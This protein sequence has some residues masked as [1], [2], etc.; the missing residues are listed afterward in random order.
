MPQAYFPPLDRCLAGEEHLISWKTAYRV[1]S[2]SDNALEERTL[3]AFLTDSDSL[4][5][6]VNPLDP[7]PHRS[8]KTKG[9]FE[10]KTAPINVSQ[11]SN[12]DYNLEELKQDAIWL[13]EK[14]DVEESIA[15]RIAVIEWQQRPADELRVALQPF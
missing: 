5:H 3:E 10:T 11:S 6:L 9:D 4:V 15:L 12:G 2:D 8:P 1:L 14:L 7:Y 13:S